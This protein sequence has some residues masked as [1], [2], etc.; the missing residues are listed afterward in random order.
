MIFTF[1]CLAKVR[2]RR[3]L[4]T[5]EMSMQIVNHAVHFRK[6]KGKI[7]QSL[8]RSVCLCDLSKWLRKS[9]S[10]WH[11]ASHEGIKRQSS[12]V[13]GPSISS[14]ATTVNFKKASCVVNLVI[15]NSS[16][17]MY[18]V[19]ILACKCHRQLHYPCTRLD[20]GKSKS[21]LKVN[22]SSVSLHRLFLSVA[23]ALVSS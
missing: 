14:H 3:V 4:C 7:Q 13:S 18:H 9:S 20:S 12:F 10:R 2:P 6:S 23:M 5:L 16:M 8:K 11:L 21:L 1:V 15:K 19:H 17:H 22:V